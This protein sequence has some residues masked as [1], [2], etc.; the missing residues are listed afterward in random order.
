MDPKE[1]EARKQ[2]GR[3]AAIALKATEPKEYGQ[4]SETVYPYT[5]WWKFGWNEVV[6]HGASR[7]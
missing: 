6:A 2:Q 3:D 7:N 4:T 5:Y 1:I